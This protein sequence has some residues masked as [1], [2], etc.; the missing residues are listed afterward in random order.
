[1][2]TRN[3]SKLRQLEEKRKAGQEKSMAL[4]VFLKRIL[5]IGTMKKHLDI[6]ATKEREHEQLKEVQVSGWLNQAPHLGFLNMGHRF[7]EPYIF[8]A[9]LK[10]LPHH[11]LW[12]TGPTKHAG[13][14]LRL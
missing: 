7:S 13:S 3:Y 14:K 5:L 12:I 4:Y 6:T 1:M 11:F 8:L 10:H 2:L 9:R